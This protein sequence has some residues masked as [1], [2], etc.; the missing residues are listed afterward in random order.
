MLRNESKCIPDQKK[1]E[2]EVKRYISLLKLPEKLKKE[3][4]TGK[5]P[6]KV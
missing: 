4:Y 1:A 3:I 2:E 6:A 5:G